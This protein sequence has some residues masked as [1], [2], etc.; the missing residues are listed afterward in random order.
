VGFAASVGQHQGFVQ[1][2]GAFVVFKKMRVGGQG[3]FTHNGHTL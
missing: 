2:G 3:T 1:G